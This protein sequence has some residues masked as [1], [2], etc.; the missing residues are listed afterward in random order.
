MRDWARGGVVLLGAVALGWGPVSAAAQTRFVWPDTIVD[1][2]TYATVEEC[3]AGAEAAKLQMVAHERLT[4]WRDTM[5]FDPRVDGNMGAL[6][7]LPAPVVTAARR[8]A[9]RFKAADSTLGRYPLSYLMP[10]YLMAGLDAEAKALVDRRIAASRK[11]GPAAADSALQRQARR[12]GKQWTGPDG[13][14]PSVEDS[15]L[16]FYLEA[17]PFRRAAIEEIFA[18]RLRGAQTAADRM[19]MLLNLLD[20]AARAQDTAQAVARATQLAA[21]LKHAMA[22]E[23]EKILDE[24]GRFRISTTDTASLPK[25]AQPAAEAVVEWLYQQELIDSLRRGTPQWVAARRAVWTRLISAE[26]AEMA[27]QD[28]K[29]E[30]VSPIKADFWFR[31]GTGE[32]TVRPTPGKVGLVYGVDNIWCVGLADSPEGRLSGER[33][34][35]WDSFAALRRLAQRFPELQV[36]IVVRTHRAMGYS[37]YPDS[38]QEAELIRRWLHEGQ[39]LPGALAVVV[40]PFS[41]LPDPDRRLLNVPMSP[42]SGQQASGLIDRVGLAVSAP[43]TLALRGLN[44][45]TEGEY[46]KLIAILL[47]QP[48]AFSR[49]PAAKRGP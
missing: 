23:R 27:V 17:Q 34:D 40:T 2:A 21:E 16:K 1:Y 31:H 47:Q 20:V 30:P 35:C 28:F 38:T 12:V 37:A 49:S 9:T 8:C 33:D 3:L 5:P 10:L 24:N 29:L 6:Q 45:T 43:T 36:T 19:G 4:A 42:G 7:P 48:A 13:L 18:A 26:Q 11:A 44:R 46:A 25:L 32:D 39:R 22:T 14:L 41:R 15:A